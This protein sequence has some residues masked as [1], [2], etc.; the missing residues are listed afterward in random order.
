MSPLLLRSLPLLTAGAA[1]AAVAALEL[2]NPRFVQRLEAN[3]YDWRIRLAR[4]YPAPAVANLGFVFMSD[5]SITRVNDG[6]LRGFRYGLYWPR[7]L[8][9]RVVEELTAQGARAIA[10]DILLPQ[11]RPDHP[12]IQLPEPGASEAESFIKRL[13][14]KERPLRVEGLLSMES[15][16]HFAWQ[17]QR[18]GRVILATERGARPWSVFAT[19]AAGMGDVSADA[20][21]DGVLRRARPF[22]LY[23]QWHP[24]FLAA[25]A[26]FGVDLDRA[27]IGTNAII[28]TPADGKPV[29]VELDANGEFNVGDFIGD[30]LPPGLA[31]RARPFTDRRIWHMGIVLAAAELGLNLD[32]A[33]VRPDRIIIQG[34]RGQHTIPLAPGGWIPI[35]WTLDIKSPQLIKESIDSLIEQQL[36]HEAGEARATNRWRGALVLIGS[37][38][39]GNDLTDRGA[40]PL[41]ETSLLIGQHWNLANSILTGQFIRATPV[42]VNLSIIVLLGALTSWLTWRL[43]AVTALVSV[44]L[45]AA[46]YVGLAAWLFVH[47]RIW[48]PMALPILGAGFFQ[49]VCL[50]TYRVVFEEREKRKVRSVFA[51]VVSPN[52]VHELLQSE[53]IAFGGALRDITVLFADVRGF[54]QLTDRNR[55]E[56]E[57]HIRDHKLDVA[58]AAA[59]L[60]QQA[61]ETLNTVNLYLAAVAD[62]VKQRGGTLDKYIGDCV[63]A[64]WGAPTPNTKHALAAVEA[65]VDAQRAIHALNVQREAENQRRAA[66]GQSPLALLS[67]GSGLNTGV[68][69]VGLMGSDQ[70]ILNYTVFGREVNLAS[71]LEGVSGRGRVIIGAATYQHLL[72]DAPELA[73]RCRPLEPTTV[74]GIAETLTC[75][76]VPWQ[77]AQAQV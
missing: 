9:G 29:T 13:H 15:D 74:K 21:P 42:E 33:L 59:Y 67:L 44:L 75:Y 34:D 48:V 76:E 18:S 3:T 22:K 39:T 17:L 23:R 37:S 53:K 63:M 40:T 46:A 38:A 31:P 60:D 50:V 32:R 56:A 30:Q 35:N 68:S 25:A 11:P 71:R 19:N 49:H 54:T 26:D 27:I 70:H 1:I 52:V 47:W 45:L 24:V 36:A 69:I 41:S 57:A 77:Q 61:R 62:I 51:K 20:D 12:P 28:L 7:H 14:P 10:F 4:R 6:S 64:F 73:A 66:A 5:E 65:A 8:Y 43:R 16:E 58:A 55:A 72:R 2:E